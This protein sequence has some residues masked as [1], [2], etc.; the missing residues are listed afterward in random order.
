MEQIKILK[1]TSKTTKPPGLKPYKMCEVECGGEIRKVNIWSNAPD[2]ANL[3]EGSIIVG[4]MAMEG[5]YW[6]ISFED[7]KPRNSGY[8]AHKEAVIEKAIVRKETFIG[9]SQD[10]KEWGIKV[11]STMN[12]AIDLAIAEYTKNPNSLFNLDECISKWR[13]WIWNHW[14]VDLKDTDP[15]TDE[16]I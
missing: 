4:K 15:T 3:Q 5:Q 11:A 10:N 14:N 16:I 12:K 2:F 9:K 6:N 13:K 1:V 8:T 7:Q